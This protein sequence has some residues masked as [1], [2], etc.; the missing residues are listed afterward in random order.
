MA[1]TQVAQGGEEQEE[2]QD[3]WK[4]R[5][6]NLCDRFPT[7]T[8]ERVSQVLMNKGGH[9]GAAAGA[10]R[11]LSSSDFKS[12]EPEDTQ[13][14]EILL[15]NPMMRMMFTTAC[16]TTF[17]KYDVNR[18][19]NL[20]WAEVLCLTNE[21]HHKFALEEPTEGSLRAFFEETD[22]NHDGVLS[23][24][25]FT[26][27]FEGFLRRA[28]ACQPQTV[29]PPASRQQQ[30]PQEDSRGERG[31]RSNR[32]R[33]N[34]AD[35]ERDRRPRDSSNT[36]QRSRRSE[37]QQQRQQHVAESRPEPREEPKRSESGLGMSLRC[38]APQGVAYR[39][40]PNLTDQTSTVV[41]RGD[42]VQVLEYWI[43]TT[44]G[45]LP[46]VD[47]RGQALFGRGASQAAEG[48]SEGA[49]GRREHRQQRDEHNGSAGGGGSR[50]R[51]TPD[52]GGGGSGNGHRGASSM[53]PPPPPQRGVEVQQQAPPPSA[54]IGPDE[55]DLREPFER[56]K[57]RFTHIPP[58]DVLQALRENDGHAGMTAKVLRDM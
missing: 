35:E 29:P 14:V 50:S 19:G 55:D 26:K 40:S 18:D 3:E 53:S 36:G 24:E 27:F 38:V 1:P 15:G 30:P 10:L 43:R 7:F 46:M 4:E 23:E 9:A 11:E 54:E 20:S 56:L 33:G 12:I 58:H 5:Y 52:S 49:G 47:T 44:D 41:H 48:A 2:W 37:Q 25:E 57:A 17:K 39:R 32:D 34:R 8:K 13:Q 6:E 31:G 42:N 21:L 51:R 16:S 45:W 28:F 22:S